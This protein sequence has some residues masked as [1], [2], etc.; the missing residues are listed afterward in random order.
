MKAMIIRGLTLQLRHPALW[1]WNVRRQTLRPAVFPIVTG[2][3]PFYFWR[4]CSSYCRLLDEQSRD[5]AAASGVRACVCV[6]VCV[7]SIYL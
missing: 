4:D 7:C 6:C 2:R 3:G 1:R 5:I